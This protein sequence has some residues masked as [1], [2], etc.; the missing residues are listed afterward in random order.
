MLACSV[1][2][3]QLSRS[4]NKLSL[5][6][7]F[8]ITWGW[9]VPY[10]QLLWVWHFEEEIKA[11]SLMLSFQSLCAN[12]KGW[13]GGMHSCKHSLIFGAWCDLCKL[14]LKVRRMES[15]FLIPHMAQ[16]TWRTWWEKKIVWMLKHTHTPLCLLKFYSFSFHLEKLPCRT[17]WLPQQ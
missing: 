17:K 5:S 10:T 14:T 8:S 2:L 3:W 6:M 13:G 11:F 12:N 4:S 16:W 7:M 15:L 9:M 1:S